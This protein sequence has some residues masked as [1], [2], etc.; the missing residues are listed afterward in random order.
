M[1]WVW[2]CVKESGGNRLG[3]FLHYKGRVEE[4]WGQCSVTVDTFFFEVVQLVVLHIFISVLKKFGNCPVTGFVVYVDDLRCSLL[5][6][7]KSFFLTDVLKAVFSKS[8][9][10]NYF[11]EFSC[12][13]F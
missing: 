1:D 12:P 7:T 10:S 2:I 3:W 11:N 4:V 8:D 13:F 9:L 6:H 5:L